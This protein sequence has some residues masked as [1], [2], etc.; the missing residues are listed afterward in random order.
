[1]RES[2]LGRW[3]VV[4]TNIR[5]DKNFLKRRMRAIIRGQAFDRRDRHFQETS[6][7]LMPA[8][9]TSSLVPANRPRERRRAGRREA[10]LRKHR[11]FARLAEGRSH[12]AIAREENCSLQWIRRIIAEALQAREA[13]PFEEFRK[14]Q[15]ARLSL[16]LQVG[17]QALMDGRLAA[18]D[19][20]LK[21]VKALDRYH[22]SKNGAEHGVGANSSVVSGAA[23]QKS[24]R[25]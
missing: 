22:G 7:M 16:A 13:D 3:L 24:Q 5:H 6:F 14:L 19:P 4:N 20:Y 23:R 10:A 21:T 9:E 1:M 11:I 2:A 17:H 25:N 15:V 18:I 12:A 8:F